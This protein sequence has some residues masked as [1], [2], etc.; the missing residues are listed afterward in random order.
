M[1][2]WTFQVFTSNLDEEVL[3]LICNR[4]IENINTFYTEIYSITFSLSWYIPIFVIN[5]RHQGT[6]AKKL[7]ELIDYSLIFQKK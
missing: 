2:I 7:Y 5:F 4:K 3:I 6:K 1:D